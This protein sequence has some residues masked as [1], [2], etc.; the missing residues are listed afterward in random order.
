VQD[1]AEATDGHLL[2]L[3]WKT[4]LL[5]KVSVVG[6]PW[7]RKERYSQLRGL[8]ID[9]ARLHET[10]AGWLAAARATET[11]LA[12]NGHRVVRVAIEPEEFVAWCSAHDFPPDAQARTRYASEFA[13]LDKRF[14]DA[15]N[16]IYRRAQQTTG[17]VE[18]HV[19]PVFTY[20][21]DGR[22]DF[23]GSGLFA[24]LDARHYLVT[25][26]HVLDACELGCVV[27]AGDATGRDLSGTRTVT[28]RPSGKTRDDD[29]FDI[30][31]IRL[32]SSEV[33]EVSSEHFLDLMHTVDGPPAEPVEAMIALGFAARDQAADRG[34]VRTKL[35]MFMTGPE[36]AHA[37][38]LAKTDP[39]SHLLV[40]H[41]RRETVFN[42]Q[43]QG[44]AP[45]VKGMSGGRI[46]QVSL[47]GEMQL[48]ESPALAAMVIEQ[49]QTYR[50][51][52][53]ATRAPLIR[54]FIRK[55]DTS[56]NA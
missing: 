46:W 23:E 22:L 39:R 32:S 3:G 17:T 50:T 2:A 43:Y 19:T 1:A 30:G 24:R 6:L 38:R 21:S 42:G 48:H 14:G 27:R 16:E 11:H 51:A 12:A 49:P 41:R 13:H 56:P 34:T 36:S 53:L 26:A 20:R 44:S 35:T 15:Q 37:Y 55:F 9:G 29:V 5:L 33:A 47:R 28:G 10:Y 52:I 7:Y 4:G 54:S 45:S 8:F 40:R 18:R 25:A 31:F